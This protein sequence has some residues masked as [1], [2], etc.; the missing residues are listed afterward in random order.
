MKNL[1][2]FTALAAAMF[3]T[4]SVALAQTAGTASANGSI[5]ASTITA[6]ANVVTD[7]TATGVTNLEFGTLY[8][9]AGGKA[10]SA[11]SATAGVFSVSGPNSTAG[12]TA[13]FT[14]PSFLTGVTPANQLAIGTWTYAVGPAAGCSGAYTNSAPFALD[15]TGAAKLCVGATIPAMSGTQA[16]DSYTGTV[17]MTVTFP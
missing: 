13:T 12:V 2:K 1:V 15:A 6:H 11:L 16:L 17:S 8:R 3:S 10:I 5:S 4:A 9:N 14:A 7:I